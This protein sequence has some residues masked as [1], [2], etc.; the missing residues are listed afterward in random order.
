[1]IQPPLQACAD[2]KWQTAAVSFAV[3]VV[4][5]IPL[6]LAVSALCAR[7]AAADWLASYTPVVYLEADASSEQAEKLAAEMREWP[8]VAT[9]EVRTPDG[10]HADLTDRLGED[11]V[12]ELGVTPGMLPTSILLQPAVPLAGHIDLVARVSGLEARPDVDA[13]EVPSSDAMQVVSFAAVGLG[14]A[15]LLA[16]FGLLAALILLAGYLRRLR[17]SDS[18]SDRVLALFGA[19]ARDL[20]RPTL[21]RGLSLGAA[22]GVGVSLLGA[23]ALL[24]WQVWSAYLV[25]VA[26]STPTAAWSVVASPSLLIPTLGVAAAWFASREPVQI[27]RRGHA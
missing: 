15:V 23:V 19:Q 14:I 3:M 7:S 25:G 24:S 6:A 11:V 26:V 20:R 16:A 9:V 13:V 17:E 18:D 21:L 12:A 1:M 2:R 8:L 4:I 5:A 22:C 27:W 10:A